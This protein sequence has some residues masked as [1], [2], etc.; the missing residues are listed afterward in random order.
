[1]GNVAVLSAVGHDDEVAV[2]VMSLLLLLLMAGFPPLVRA[3]LGSGFLRYF[4]DKKICKPVVLSRGGCTAAGFVA[5]GTRAGVNGGLAYTPVLVAEMGADS[6]GV[7]VAG[8]TAAVRVDDT[9]TGSPAV[10]VFSFARS[11]LLLLLFVLFVLFVLLTASAISTSCWSDEVD[12]VVVVGAGAIVVGPELEVAVM[13]EG[14]SP[15]ANG[16][17]IGPTPWPLSSTICCGK[18]L[19]VVRD[20]VAKELAAAA[21]GAVEVVVEGLGEVAFDVEVAVMLFSG[22]LRES[23]FEWVF[24]SALLGV[25][26]LWGILKA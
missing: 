3:V 9:E 4:S 12:E 22:L 24:S 16:T 14:V 15:K 6:A 1:V 11:L 25:A 5:V 20:V 10:E 26:L 18:V 19:A 13:S 8:G 7:A 23:S 21:P 17:S 2:V